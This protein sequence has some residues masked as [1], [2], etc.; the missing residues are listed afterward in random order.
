ATRSRERFKRISKED[1]IKGESDFIHK[2]EKLLLVVDVKITLALKLE[3]DEPLHEKYD[4]DLERIK[5]L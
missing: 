2:C 1:Q 5:L 4:D 3:V